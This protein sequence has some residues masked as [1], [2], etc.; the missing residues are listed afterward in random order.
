MISAGTVT[1]TN[2]MVFQTQYS[3]DNVNWFDSGLTITL[4]SSVLQGMAVGILT[5]SPYVRLQYIPD[6][7]SL[8]DSATDVTIW[9]PTKA[10]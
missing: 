10:I 8:T 4:T 5:A 2:G 1:S 7:L 6:L 3:P 9:I